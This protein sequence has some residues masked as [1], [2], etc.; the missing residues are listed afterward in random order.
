MTGTDEAFRAAEGIAKTS[1]FNSLPILPEEIA[2]RH[3]ILVDAMPPSSEGGV[4]GMMIRVRENYGI[5]YATHIDN[6]GF[7]NFS[8]GH[9]LGHYFLPG[10][11][12]AVTVNGVHQTYS[13]RESDD[14]YEREADAF[15]AGLL[16]PTYLFKPA[17]HKV[18]LG[19][20]GIQTLSELC[21]TSLTTTAI[22]FV[23][24]VSD[25]LAIVV[26]KGD[27]IAYSFISDE[28]SEYPGVSRLRRGSLLPD[29]L[30]RQF[31]ID[32]SNVS[33]AQ[34]D[35]S[36]SDFQSWFDSPVEGTLSEEVVGLGSY[37]RTLTVLT[38]AALP[39]LEELDE[40]TL[41]QESWTP[42]I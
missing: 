1:G 9:E 24:T 7:Q 37:G 40:E 38:A 5:L 25:P 15:A 35:E 30:T 26:S 4:S 29:T 17:A 18:E 42:R 36:V 41:L 39:N 6:R 14:V 33:E 34:R 27:R 32:Q 16:M 11:I 2:K 28:L 22:Q 3:G 21:G 8:I 10:H 20:D 23:K 19:F 31:N 12:D 13:Y